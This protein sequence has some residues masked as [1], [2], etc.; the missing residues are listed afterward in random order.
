MFN[1]YQQPWTMV[2]IAII[3]LFVI[4]TYRSVVPEKKRAWQLLIPLLIVLAGFGID[5]AV[6]TDKEKINDIIVS[7]INAVKTE[8]FNSIDSYISDDYRDSYHRS[9]DQLISHVQGRLRMNEVE[10]AKKT[11]IVIMVNGNVAKVNLFMK[12]V[13]NQNSEIKQEFNIS[14]VPMKI[15]LTFIK[16]NNKWLINCIELRSVNLQ[17]V[18]WSE[19]G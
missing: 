17:P 9:K 4:L 7:G 18:R 1:F 10:K 16:Q 8:N 6:T 5:R 19:V 13:L 11:N 3:V 2:G 15:D 14:V 12:I